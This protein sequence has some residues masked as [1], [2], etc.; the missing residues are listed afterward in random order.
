MEVGTAY[1]A[2]KTAFEKIKLMG[3]AI[4]QSTENQRVMKNR[5]NQQVSTISELLDADFLV[6]QAK[7]NQV[8]AKA[9]AE[10]AYF[11]FLKAAGK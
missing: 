8:T 1:F 9:D 7:V 11:R 5:Y 2:Y 4:V 10:L 3:K 6:L